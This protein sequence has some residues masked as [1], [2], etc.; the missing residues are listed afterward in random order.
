M[1]HE[2]LGVAAGV[3]GALAIWDMSLRF[4]GRYSRWAHRRLIRRSIRAEYPDPVE[5]WDDEK[6][7]LVR[8]PREEFIRRQV[9]QHG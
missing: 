7:E 9:E 6:Q 1:W 5:I 3:A 4:M 8:V 2:A